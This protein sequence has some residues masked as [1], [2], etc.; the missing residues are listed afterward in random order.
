MNGGRG[1][2]R[3]RLTRCVDRR[4]D[5]T[6][7]PVGVLWGGSQQRKRERKTRELGS[8]E[9]LKKETV[10]GRS[11]SDRGVRD[12]PR[13]VGIS[14]E[15]GHVKFPLCHPEGA[16]TKLKTDRQRGERSP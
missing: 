6:G 3:W 10:E 12:L 15:R 7:G 16:Y 5:Q 13:D 9:G 11:K 1:S 4:E 14:A 8:S 2:T